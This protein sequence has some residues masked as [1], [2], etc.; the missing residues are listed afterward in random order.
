MP[1][2]LVIWK[3]IMS[4]RFRKKAAFYILVL[5]F[6]LVSSGT[7]ELSQYNKILDYALNLLKCKN[8]EITYDEEGK[9][10]SISN[11]VIDLN[12]IEIAKAYFKL[13]FQ[14]EAIGLLEKIILEDNKYKLLNILV[15]SEVDKKKNIRTEIKRRIKKL[16]NKFHQIYLYTDLI[17]DYLRDFQKQKAEQ[18]FIER[19]GIMERMRKTDKDG[20]EFFIGYSLSMI[21]LLEENEL[22]V[23]SEKLLKNVENYISK[24]PNFELMELLLKKYIELNMIDKADEIIKK[25]KTN[26]IKNPKNLYRIAVLLLKLE[27]YYEAENLLLETFNIFRDRVHIDETYGDLVGFMELNDIFETPLV[28]NLIGKNEKIRQIIKDNLKKKILV[29]AGTKY[30]FLDENDKLTELLVLTGDYQEALNWARKL[31]KKNNTNKYKDYYYYQMGLI[32]EKSFEINAIV[33][34]AEKIKMRSLAVDLLLRVSRYYKMAQEKDMFKRVMNKAT[35]IVS[36]VKDDSFIFGD[37][38]DVVLAWLDGGFF[39][40]AYETIKYEQN[41]RSR[42]LLLFEVAQ[43]YILKNNVD[44]AEKLIYEID[45]E[46]HKALVLSKIAS[47]FMIN[48]KEKKGIEYFKKAI[49]I[50]ILNNG[51]YLNQILSDYINAI[52]D[53]KIIKTNLWEMSK[54]VH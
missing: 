17:I 29:N 54:V 26:V 33:L 2:I 34:M 53:K 35:C 16:N 1:W 36:K 4:K 14:V 45:V 19:D 8:V 3:Y 7:K 37:V 10:K 47:M 6:C 27:R 30:K 5:F 50:E 24:E 43:S 32:F 13:G 38:G 31:D 40:E 28:L 51:H 49:N 42:S 21:C 52:K 20:Y 46:D 44:K 39:N 11:S 25:M 41:K 12:Y 9:I 48:C 15:H 18:M 23:L 22:K